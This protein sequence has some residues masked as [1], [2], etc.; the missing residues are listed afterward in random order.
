MGEKRKD[1]KGRILRT[2][3]SQRANGTYMYRYTSPSGEKRWCY[4]PTL[5][6]L[7][8]KEE[9]IQNDLHDEIDT[10]SSE[11]RVINLVERYVS[12]K[13]NA[14]RTTQVGYAFAIKVLKKQKFS[15]KRV[16]DV[17]PL[18]ARLLFVGL[19]EKVGY[20]YATIMAIRGV[21]KPAFEMAIEDDIIR[22]NPFAF[23]VSEIVKKDAVSKV[24]LAQEQRE[25]YL[26]FILEDTCRAKYYDEVVILLETRLRVSE[27]Y[28]LTIPDVDLVNRRIYV[29]R[30]LRM[31]DADGKYYV[32]E[33]KTK[34]GIRVVPLSSAACVAFKSALEN[35]PHPDVEVAID[36]CEKFLFL[37]RTGK[38]RASDNL[39]HG[40]KDIIKKY[41]KPHE[42]QLPNITPHTFRHTF[43][44]DMYNGG[45]DIKT[46]QSI[47]GHSNVQ[48]TLDI[49]T[50]TNPERTC[51]E[52]F[53]AI[54]EL[55]ESAAE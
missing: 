52:Y 3:E 42:V 46:I 47:V 48:T 39:Q 21:L 25:A 29:K 12:L 19:N 20:S 50:H 14:R 43:I 36:G 10:S 27:L 24:A 15:E 17:R 41:N 7:R 18:D 16:Q 1:N 35:R 26:A 2:E 55:T 54:G 45:L 9:D 8:E 28:G 11:M 13:R 40:L 32:D 33:P 5:Q 44:T 53:K 51:N 37:N 38:P 4:A 23:N 22:R 49:Y 34:N 30:Q 31:N 6:T